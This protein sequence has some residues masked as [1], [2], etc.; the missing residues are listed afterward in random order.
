ML[1]ELLPFVE[2]THEK[3]DDNP[4]AAAIEYLEYHYKEPCKVEDLAE[5]CFLSP[6][7]FFYRFKEQTGFSPIVY[8]NRLCIRHA[9]Q[10]LLLEKH[11]SI[12]EISEEYGF[13]SAVYFRRLFKSVTGKTP[14]NYRREE[15][16][17]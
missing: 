4:V 5:L 6:S 10:A 3:P 2:H 13:E 9:A 17:L 11:K 8:K 12:E 14:T 15:A 7:R 1:G 16:L